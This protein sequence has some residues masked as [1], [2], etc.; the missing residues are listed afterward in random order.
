[1]SEMKKAEI[2]SHYCANLDDNVFIAI[3]DGKDGKKRRCL[4]SHL[5]RADER[6]LCGRTDEMRRENHG[7]AI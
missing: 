1:M 3:S 5:C 2:T 4:S 6:A 7:T